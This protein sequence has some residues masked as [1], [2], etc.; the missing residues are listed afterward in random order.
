MTLAGDRM[1]DSPAENVTFE[2]ALAE[3]DRI[4]RELED[5]GVGLEE[6][7]ARYEQGVGLLKRCYAHLRQAEQ[8]IQ[9]LAGLDSE[10][11]PILK[12][13]DHTATVE[14]DSQET[15]RPRKK[16]SEGEIPF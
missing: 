15:K 3:L 11:R 14:A 2:Q 13:F 12:P 8:R 9:L 6:S 5:G 10:G 1:A 7:L 16:N 4:V